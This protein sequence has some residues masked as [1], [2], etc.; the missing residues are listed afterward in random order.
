M[1]ALEVT[2]R[3]LGQEHPYTLISMNNLAITWKSLGRNSEALALMDKCVQLREQILGSN[4][5]HTVISLG[6]LD[7][8]KTENL[9]LNS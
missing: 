4:H 7:E 6:I 1:Q 2:K 8:W 5:P 3:V 9:A